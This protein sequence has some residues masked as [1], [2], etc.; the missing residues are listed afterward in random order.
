MLIDLTTKRERFDHSAMEPSRL[1][2]DGYNFYYWGNY[3]GFNREGQ[4]EVAMLHD[5]VIKFDPA[6]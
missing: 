3:L 4:F 5:G 2:P 1:E 6:R